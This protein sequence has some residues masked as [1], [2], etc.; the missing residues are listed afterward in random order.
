M[1]TRFLAASA[2]SA[3]VLLA[4]ASAGAQGFGKNKVQYE[5]LE[6][7]V[8]ETPHLR[9]HYYAEEESLARSLAAFAESVTVEYAQR[10]RIR[11]RP[12][13]PLLFYSTHHLFQ[14]T[15][16]TPDLLRES[17][18]GLTDPIKA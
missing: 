14:Q 1:S 6:W 17:V 11:P 15:H 5:S 10:F 4:S 12:K 13:V 7:S 9:L 18:G 8:L 16:A 2:L 3:A